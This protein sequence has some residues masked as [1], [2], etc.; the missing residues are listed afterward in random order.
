MVRAML[1]APPHPVSISTNKGNELAAVILFASAK[2]SSM[3]VIPRSGI[4]C[5]AAATPP[6]DK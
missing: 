3:V 2:T 6:P 1:K 4:P 5:E